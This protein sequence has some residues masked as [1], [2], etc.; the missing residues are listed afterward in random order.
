MGLTCMHSNLGANATGSWW[1]QVIRPVV[2]T[3]GL[4]SS[5][6]TAANTVLFAIASKEFQPDMS[7]EYLKPVGLVGKSSKCANDPAL[8]GD[9]WEWTERRMR[10]S[11]LLE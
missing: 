7:G 8:A 4:Y 11:G 6:E 2:R 1:F 10:Y 9:L 3:L 5:I